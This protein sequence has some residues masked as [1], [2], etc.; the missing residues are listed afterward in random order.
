MNVA[1]LLKS[2]VSRRWIG[3]TLAVL[4][5]MA[6]LVRLGFWQLDRLE[7]RRAQ[8]AQLGAVLEGAPLQLPTDELPASTAEW[9]NRLV[10][11]SGT[12]DYAHEGRLILQSWGGRNGVHLITPLLIDGSNTA[13]LVDRG[14][15]PDD[16]ATPDKLAAYQT[17]TTVSVAGYIALT[18]TLRRQ[19]ETAVTG[20]E[21]YRVDVAAIA[22]QLPYD[23]YPF[24]IIESPAAGGD[25]ALPY[26]A[27]R[28]IDLSEGPHLSYAIQWFIFATTLGVIYL[29]LVA[30]R[31]QANE[32]ANEA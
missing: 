3:A 12:Y 15:I 17:Q 16:E 5:G 20:A 7:Q 23:V 11:V 21:W 27:E 2:L 4:L 25:Q 31:S 1:K 9:E 32:V 10:T 29:V 28:Q 30:R 18:Q 6:L 24:Y 19:P 26:R 13:V 14:W 8:N 22:A